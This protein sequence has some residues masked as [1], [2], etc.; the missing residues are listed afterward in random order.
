MKTTNISVSLNTPDGRKQYTG[1]G[2]IAYPFVIHRPIMSVREMAAGDTYWCVSH[3]ASG[4]KAFNARTIQ[5]AKRMVSILGRFDLF[6]MP[7]CDR[8]YE[9]CRAQGRNV[10]NTLENEGWSPSTMRF[11]NVYV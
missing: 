1:R 3:I 11:K 10:Q 9:L 8:F 4:R 2:I 5:D 6:K 7:E